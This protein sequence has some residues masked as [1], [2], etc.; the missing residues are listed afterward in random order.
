MK[1]WIIPEGTIEEGSPV[2]GG[3]VRSWK[4]PCVAK[5]TWRPEKMAGC[6]RKGW[7]HTKRKR[8][9]LDLFSTQE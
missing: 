6:E 8:V 4:G 3:S 9:E 7:G 5:N 2:E 1:M